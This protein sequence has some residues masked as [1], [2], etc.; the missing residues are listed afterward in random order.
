MKEKSMTAAASQNGDHLFSRPPEVSYKGN[1]D[2]VV[3]ES[4]EQDPAIS[5]F[6]ADGS[7][8]G[9]ELMAAA[10][11]RASEKLTLSG[12]ATDLTEIRA[13]L[14]DIRPDVAI[15]SGDMKVGAPTAFDLAREI[16]ESHPKTNIV[17]MLESIE[18]VMVV[19]AFR[20]GAT[21]IFSRDKS[22]DLLCACIRAVHEG[23]IWA[24]N[25]SIRFLLD[26]FI[27]GTSRDAT[28]FKR[29]NILT[30]REESVVQ[31]VADGLTNRDISRQLNLSENTIRNYLF[32][33]FN[34]VGTSNRLEL[35]LYAV[36]K[37]KG[38]GQRNHAN[39][40]SAPKIIE[41]VPS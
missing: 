21:G 17:M 41:N 5:V 9:C 24:D 28:S 8:M 37:K 27:R 19:E 38:A 31:L 32:R 14:R 34:K 23:Q 13:R 30:K 33:I 4:P 26:A 10:L 20:A 36:N 22:F 6:L 1:C 16:K 3:M 18:R 12:Y 29:P 25:Q 35:A 39:R 15:I 40:D 2:R 11:Q 7:R